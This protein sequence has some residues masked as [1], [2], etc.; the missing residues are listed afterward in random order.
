MAVREIEAFDLRACLRGAGVTS[1]SEHHA[2]RGIAGP[3]DFKFTQS[4][5]RYRREDFGQITP[6]SHQNR[7]S[8]RISETN[9][10]FQNARTI[11]SQHQPNEQNAAERKAF[12]PRS[13]QCRLDNVAHNVHGA[14]HGA[15]NAARQPNDAPLAVAN[16]RDA[17]EGPGNARAVVTG[18]VADV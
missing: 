17:M 13:L 2:R 14:E 7:L 5:F 18:K 1:R 16:R 15:P 10:I 11:G 8:L 12:I 4:L 9:V 3:I 6:Q